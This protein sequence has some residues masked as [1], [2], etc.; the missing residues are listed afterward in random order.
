MSS[1]GTRGGT[2]LTGP[3]G[4]AVSPAQ[5]CGFGGPPAIRPSGSGAPRRP[6][7][8]RKRLHAVRDAARCLPVEG[9][10]YAYAGPLIGP[11]L[12][13]WAVPRHGEAELSRLGLSLPRNSQNRPRQGLKGITAQGRKAVRW[14]CRLLEDMR[15]RC[16]MWTVS[17]PDNDYLLLSRSG[18]WP[19]FQTRIH[20]LLVRYLK[21][22]GD[23]A[24]VVGVCE[25]GPKRFSATGVPMPHIHVI[26]SGWGSRRPDGQWLLCPDAMDQLVAK[27]CQYAGLP[28]AHRPA[29]SRV[30]PVRHS[31]A[32]YLSKYLT[33]EMPVKSEDLPEEWQSLIPRQWWFR[34]AACKALVEGCL[35]KLPP[36][37][38]AF[39]ARCHGKLEGLGLGRGGY[40]VVARR[41]TLL[42]TVPIEMLK[43]RFKGTDELFIAIELFLIWVTNDERLDVA[44]LGMSG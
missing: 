31:V 8:L 21:E 11:D 19:K 39:V 2:A 43:F 38:A 25:I 32:S 10:D 24:L 20:D 7:G 18:E 13:V 22:H 35:I 41:E 26:T 6:K 14:S 17:L 44:A 3:C 1:A 28:S 33:K 27:A 42:G 34:S 9:R 29:A 36:A 15:R 16:A 23:G 12:K 30:E 5:R 4:L 37:F 40:S